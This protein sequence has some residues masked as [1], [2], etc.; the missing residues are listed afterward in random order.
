MQAKKGQWVQIHNIILEPSERAPQVPDD[1][2]QTPL[3][4]WV[5]GYLTADAE[6][7]GECEITTITGRR[8]KGVLDEIEPAYSHDYGKYI[9]ELNTIRNQVKGIIGGETL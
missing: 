7:G 2:K 4:M 5:K 8:L 1:T 9:P 6:I 3:V